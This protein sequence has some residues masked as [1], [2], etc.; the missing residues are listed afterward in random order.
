VTQSV[1]MAGKECTLRNNCFVIWSSLFEFRRA[2][3]QTVAIGGDIL[4]ALFL[5]LAWMVHS[6]RSLSWGEEDGV[7]NSLV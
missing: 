7:L 4:N 6:T 1:A 2:I 3:T 5:C